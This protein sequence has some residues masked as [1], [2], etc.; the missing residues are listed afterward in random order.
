MVSVPFLFGMMAGQPQWIHLPLF[1]GWL[2]LYLSSYPF[3]QF[4]KRT[5]HRGHWLKWGT[6]YGA[7]SIV[8]LVPLVI[9]NPSLLYFVPLLLGLLMVNIWHTMQKSE[10]AM[11][12][13]VCA[14]LI[15]SVG[16]PAAYLLGGGGWDPTMALIMLFSFLHF[17]GSVFFV[18][19]VFRERKNQRWINYAKVYHVIV[20]FIP[21]AVG[22]P[23]MFLAFL[24]STVRTFT[25]GGEI[26]RPWKV[27]IIEIIGAVQFLILSVAVINL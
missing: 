8:F 16:G 19:S 23:W 12:N 24:Y 10:R 14:I 25:F 4:L 20:L 17:M 7:I 27:G 15:F 6:V 9:F 2:F 18:K 26:Q 21:L 3:L 5:T 22:I 1:L 11:L 13:N